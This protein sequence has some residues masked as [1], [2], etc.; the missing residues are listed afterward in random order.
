MQV[1]YYRSP[2]FI[3]ITL[4]PGQTATFSVKQGPTVLAAGNFVRS[5]GTGSTA[6]ATIPALFPNHNEAVVE[7]VITNPD[8]TQDIRDFDVYIDPSGF[9]RTVSGEPVVGATVVLQRSAAAGGPFAQVP[10]GSTIMSPSNRD[11]PDLTDADGH[12]G[13]DTIAGFYKVTA[14]KAGCHA[15]GSDASEVS[16]PELQVPPP[17]TDLDLRLDC[18]PGAASA[19]PDGAGAGAGSGGSNGSKPRPLRLRLGNRN[20]QLKVNRDGEVT[21]EFVAQDED[22][23]GNVRLLDTRRKKGGGRNKVQ[24]AE[25]G[26]VAESGQRVVATMVLEKDALRRLRH[27]GQM[28]V[29]APASLNSESGSTKREL[30]FLLRYS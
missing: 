7:I 12:F 23:T 18:A 3:T 16:T 1:I 2:S 22:T 15:P 4:A 19:G 20:H 13:W 24:I 27:A 30:S 17:V 29:D 5:G 21:V 14:S 25:S 26:L 11:N 8:G 28:R 10:N 6:T 9:V